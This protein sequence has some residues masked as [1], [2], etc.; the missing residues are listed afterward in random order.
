VSAPEIVGIALGGWIALSLLAVAV[1]AVAC[2]HH[3]RRM[4]RR[5]R[6]RDRAGA[7][8]RAAQV[9]LFPRHHVKGTLRDAP[10]DWQLADSP[11]LDLPAAWAKLEAG[12]PALAANLQKLLDKHR[13]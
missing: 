12:G 8:E 10:Y 2:I 11:E 5:E 1:L 7:Q 9:L 4:H 6:A 3:D 13:A